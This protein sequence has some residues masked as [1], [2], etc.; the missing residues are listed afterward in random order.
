MNAYHSENYVTAATAQFT[1]SEEEI[2]LGRLP[3][4]LEDLPVSRLPAPGHKKLN[5]D[6]Q[7]GDWQ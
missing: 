6:E 2:L 3:F 1:L 4:D 5:A 7:A